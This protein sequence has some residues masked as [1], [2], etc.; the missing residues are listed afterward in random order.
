MYFELIFRV[1]EH[2]RDFYNK[3]SIDFIALLSTCQPCLNKSKTFGL[4]Q[5]IH[6]YNSNNLIE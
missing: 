6:I 3:Q 1:F 4:L 5:K 2:N